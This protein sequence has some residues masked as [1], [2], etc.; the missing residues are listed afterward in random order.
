MKKDNEI[1]TDL[2]VNFFYENTKTDM[3]SSNLVS[4]EP[5]L[6]SLKGI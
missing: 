5:Q 4:Q 6:R 1:V 3:I 2:F